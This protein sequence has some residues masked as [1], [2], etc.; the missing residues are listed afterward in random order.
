MTQ[1]PDIAT[2]IILALATFRLSRLFTTDVIFEPLREWVWK[3][4]DP[5]TTVG[6]LFTCNWCM[7]IWF[8]SLIVICYTIVPAV[9]ILP[10]L[11]LALSAVAG[12]ISDKLDS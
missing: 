8:A 12:L 6:Y 4:K 7:S 9:T 5:S 10:C 3:R 2:L 1:L 11:I